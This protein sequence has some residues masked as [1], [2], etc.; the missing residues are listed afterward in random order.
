VRVGGVGPASAAIVE[1]GDQERVGELGYG[2]SWR[3]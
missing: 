3:A 2:I 1:P